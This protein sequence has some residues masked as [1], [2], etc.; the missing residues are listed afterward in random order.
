MVITSSEFR[1]YSD[2]S[3]NLIVAWKTNIQ[4]ENLDFYAKTQIR[5][6]SSTKQ[7]WTLVGLEIHRKKETN[8]I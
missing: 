6:L 7:M 5:N 4:S 8:T 2:I 1:A 3:R